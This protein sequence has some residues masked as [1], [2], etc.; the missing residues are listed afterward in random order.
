M[1]F[2]TAEMDYNPSFVDIDHSGINTYLFAGS[3]SWG[4]MARQADYVLLNDGAGHLYIG[5]HDEF[6]ALASKVFAFLG[7]PFNSSSTPPRFIGIPQPDGS[8]NFVAEIPTSTF[9]AAA[10]ISQ[11]TY[12]Y[13]NV[14]LR[15]HRPAYRFHS[16]I[17]V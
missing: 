13:V 12:Q 2:N 5:L 9:N 8:I 10:N 3:M 17:A 11:A 7:M 6:T 16:M 1:S 4:S 14:P 15:C